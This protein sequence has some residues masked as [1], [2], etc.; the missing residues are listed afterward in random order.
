MYHDKW[1]FRHHW[2]SSFQFVA[3]HSTQWYFGLQQ[4]SKT[5]GCLEALFSVLPIRNACSFLSYLARTVCLSTVICF[6]WAHVKFKSWL[7]RHF[8]VRRQRERW[9]EEKTKGNHGLPGCHNNSAT[10]GS[11][12]LLSFKCIF[13]TKQARRLAIYV[14]H[15]AVI[16]MCGCFFAS[17]S[18]WMTR[19]AHCLFLFSL[20]FV[21]L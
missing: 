4:Y 9:T 19:C 3:V 18:Q 15:L 11:Y 21:G 16:V 12:L 7:K 5:H 10:V 17:V 8:W 20:C 6:H 14:S 13:V 1:T 2:P